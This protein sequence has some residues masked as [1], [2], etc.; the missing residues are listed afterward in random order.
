MSWYNISTDEIRRNKAQYLELREVHCGFCT[1]LI[2]D[3]TT[4]TC[5]F[6]GTTAP[7]ISTPRKVINHAKK[8]TDI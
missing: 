8:S 3:R 5:S 6:C 7:S 4:Y 1:R 2:T